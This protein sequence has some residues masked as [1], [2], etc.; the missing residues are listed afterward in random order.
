MYLVILGKVLKILGML[1][2]A[3][4]LIGEE[5]LVKLENTIHKCLK[6]FLTGTIIRKFILDIIN[7]VSAKIFFPIFVI[8][9]LVNAVFIVAVF[10]DINLYQYV[11]LLMNSILG[12]FAQNIL[13]IKVL[14]VLLALII[15]LFLLSFTIIGF[16]YWIFRYQIGIDRTIME[17][18]FFSGGLAK[19]ISLILTYILFM[20]PIMFLLF[21]YC[22]IF[23]L[24]IPYNFANL[25]K[26]KYK[27][28]SVFG[29]L[30]VIL[31]I[32]GI[33]IS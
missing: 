6:P 24:L 26:I 4:S 17:K 29:V 32:S 33:L 22:F 8:Y 23:L 30:G 20:I 11:A 1:F 3:T 5:R 2:L 13:I 19:I 31:N 14:R 16:Y 10:F 15:V 7:R 27:L 21:L 9:F 25:L 18:E 12:E 28:R